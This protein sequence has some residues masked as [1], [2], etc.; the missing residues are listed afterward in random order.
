LRN[1]FSD[2]DRFLQLIS[3]ELEVVTAEICFPD[4]QHFLELT[5]KLPEFQRKQRDTP[6]WEDQERPFSGE[7]LAELNQIANEFDYSP[8]KHIED[9]QKRLRQ[10]MKDGRAGLNHEMIFLNFYCNLDEFLKSIDPPLE[11]VKEKTEICSSDSYHFLRLTVKLPCIGQ[12]RSDS[13]QSVG[14]H[15]SSQPY[16]G[17]TSSSDSNAVSGTEEV[18]QQTQGNVEGE[19]QASHTDSDSNAVSGTEDEFQQTQGNVEGEVQASSNAVSG[20]EDEFQHTQGDV[21]GE[22]E[23]SLTLQSA[24]ETTALATTEVTMAVCHAL[25]GGLLVDCMNSAARMLAGSILPSRT[26]TSSAEVVEV[27]VT[28]LPSGCKIDEA[29]RLLKKHPGCWLVAEKKEH[30]S[31]G[32]YWGDSIA[33][34]PIEE[35]LSHELCWKSIV[36]MGDEDVLEYIKTDVLGAVV[37]NV[38]IDKMRWVKHSISLTTTDPWDFWVAMGYPSRQKKTVRKAGTS[39]WRSI[40]SH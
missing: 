13:K 22:D 36:I 34:V 14:S 3:P 15:S 29:R 37:R 25:S 28:K 9:L 19:V 5:V 24:M 30:G 2:L 26:T 12:P 23:T 11:V 8:S 35:Q 6:E 18:F 7:F 33:R 17:S 10:A 20:T 31:L 39:F 32:W 40:T 1:F 38:G 27:H 4:S 16:V 21:E